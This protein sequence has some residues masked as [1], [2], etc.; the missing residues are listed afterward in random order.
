MTKLIQ[1]DGINGGGQM[2]RSALSLAMITGQPFRMVNIRGKRSKPGLM[3]QHLT[4]VLA[5]QEISDGSVDGA[6]IGSTELVFRGGEIRGGSY[7]FSIGTAGS[8]S[9]L[10]QTLLPALLHAAAPSNIRLE[11]GTINPLAPPF[12]F[13]DKAYMPTIRKM[14]VNAELTLHQ[15]GFA[16]AGGG[17]MEAA[18]QP[19][20]KFG[21]L[22]LHDRGALESV[23]IRVVVRALNESIAR[24]IL[25]SACVT[26]PC[27]DT[28]IEIREDGPG[29]GIGCLVGAKFTNA[30]EMS[31]AL[32]E[33]GVS[34]ESVGHRAAN[35]I[36]RFIDSDATVGRNLADQ[37]LLPMALAGGGSF[38]MMKPS[39]HV[40]S[41]ISVIE[42]FLPVKFKIEVADRGRH[43]LTCHDG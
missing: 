7:Q 35:S 18:I 13:L 28:E 37:L 14:G 2:L 4:C 42:K 1:L 15:T 8:T 39:A 34:A 26:L 25:D 31:C 30:H 5:S 20:N 33:M 3:R 23:S 19:I 9:L 40:L 32:A 36:K 6:E 16:P 12:E 29:R 11:G 22:D 21:V 41:N 24:R 10:F 43:I 27:E 17:L 38:V